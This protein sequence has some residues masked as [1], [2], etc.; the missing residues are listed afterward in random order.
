MV[1]LGLR[2]TEDKWLLS[3]GVTGR[4][5]GDRGIGLD[6]LS[7]SIRSGYTG[8]LRCQTARMEVDHRRSRVDWLHLDLL[9]CICNDRCRHGGWLNLK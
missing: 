5:S 3:D 4:E 8:D 9:D 1:S 7:V 6:V 2:C